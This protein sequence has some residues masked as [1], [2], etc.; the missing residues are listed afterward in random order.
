MDTYIDLQ[1]PKEYHDTPVKK[2]ETIYLILHGIEKNR[3]IKLGSTNKYYKYTMKKL[4]GKKIRGYFRKTKI[5]ETKDKLKKLDKKN[6]YIQEAR[7]LKIKD[8]KTKKLRDKGKKK[9]K[10]VEMR[11]KY[12]CVYCHSYLSNTG[13]KHTPKCD[14]KKK[15][16]PCN[17]YIFDKDEY[18]KMDEKQIKDK[19][20]QMDKNKNILSE[21]ELE[22]DDEELEYD[23]ELEEENDEEFEDDDEELEFE[24]LE[25]EEEDEKEEKQENEIIYQ[26]TNYVKTIEIDKIDY[27]DKK[28]NPLEYEIMLKLRKIEHFPKI[29]ID[30]T[31]NN[32]HIITMPYYEGKKIQFDENIWFVKNYIKSLLLSI[33]R[34]IDEGYV[35]GDIKPDNFIYNNPKNYYLIDF[36]ASDEINKENNNKKMGTFP[37]IPPEKN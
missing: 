14:T 30:K 11:L 35:H 26:K 37:C 18:K 24:E 6:A 33:K 15:I 20:A 27:I 9:I 4:L 29:F 12:R 21:E 22:D 10:D 2:Y 31:I 7:M 28:V 13:M 34:L 5:L 19:K 23:E 32:E 16:Y 36:N 17:F 1:I 8:K 25:D 3:E